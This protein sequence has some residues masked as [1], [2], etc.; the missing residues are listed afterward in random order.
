MARYATGKYAKAISD[1]SGMEFPYKEM[2]REWNGAFVHF[3]EFEPKQPQLEPKPNGAD[4]VSLLN[5]RTDRTEPP[6]AV[7]LP[8]D[9]FTVTNGSAT[10]T[11]SLL[12]H[13]LKVGDFVLFFDGA[14]NAPT[15]SFN[16]GS[17]LFPLFAVT[18]AMAAADTSAILDSNT[19]FPAS[20]FYFIQSPTEPAATNPNNVPVIQR[21]V[22]QYTGKSGGLTITGL[23][24]G[25]NAP[26][27]GITNESTTATAHISSSVFP[28]LE[29]QSVT[30]RT[31]NTGAMPATKTVN[32]GFTVTL[33]YNAVG[34]ITGGGQN[35]FV[36]PMFRGVM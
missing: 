25:T 5:T 30:T 12:N 24:R 19:N 11:V 1:R 34:N 15:Q 20:G 22:I 14:S 26:F 27:R 10:L 18:T 31:E 8:K 36:S 2:V 9:P 21:E 7:A 6:T 35:A 16:L 32:T 33:P 29:I 3:T 28:G 17:N 13:S 4:G 23:S